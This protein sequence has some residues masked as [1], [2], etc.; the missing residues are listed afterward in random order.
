MIEALQSQRLFC[1]IEM[2]LQPGGIQHRG[3]GVEEERDRP[4][5]PARKHAMQEPYFDAGL[6]I[7]HIENPQGVTM[8]R[9]PQGIGGTK[10]DAQ[11]SRDK[12]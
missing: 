5:Q 1:G 7:R 9:A 6:K 2:H 4:D 10:A 11:P 3:Q 12:G 8:G